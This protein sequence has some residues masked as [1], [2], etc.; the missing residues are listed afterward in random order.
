MTDPESA[1]EEARASA[2][3]MRASGAYG[4]GDTVGQ[5]PGPLTPEKLQGW[6]LIEPEQPAPPSSRLLGRPIQGVRRLLLRL[7][8]QYHANLVAEQTRFNVGAAAAL[9][10]LEERV[11]ELERRLDEQRK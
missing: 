7:L 4:G 9:Q 3:S 6:A 1:L 5:E 10:R 11:D 2:A 8:W